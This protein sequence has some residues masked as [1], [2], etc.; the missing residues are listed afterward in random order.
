MDRNLNIK[1]AY[2]YFTLGM[3]Q[4]EIAKRLSFTRQKINQIINSLPDQEIVSINIHG[5]E[6]D[7]VELEMQVEEKYGL[8]EV[9]IASDYGEAD[10]ALYKVANVA[11]QYL[12]EIIRQGD[13]IGVSWGKTLA[14]VVKQMPFKRRAECCVVQLMG[15]QNFEQSVEKSDEIAR[16]MANRLDCA[17][18]MLYAPVVVENAE[19]K[20]WLLKEKSV[21][22]SYEWMKKC[23]IAV[24]GVG[25]LTE[26]STMCTRG[27][28]TKEDIHILQEQGFVGDIAVNPLREDGSYDHCPIADRVL[29][30]DMECLKNI[31]NT[32]LVACGTRKVRAIRAALNSGCIDTLVID[33]T[34]ARQVMEMV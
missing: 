18:Y 26:E 21:K 3:T 19:T 13:I 15:A 31:R 4:D 6:R 9:I 17:S 8:K 20:K 5:Y 11:G 10:T 29:A 23:N 2:W 14:E 30:A 25:E 22:A 33:E 28:I 16:G 12:D 32:V 24:L 1:I 34:T 7:H 27:Y